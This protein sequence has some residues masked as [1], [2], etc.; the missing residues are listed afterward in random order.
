VEPRQVQQRALTAR[1]FALDHPTTNNQAFPSLHRYIRDS[2]QASSEREPSRAAA[3][4]QS[5]H[6]PFTHS[7]PLVEESSLHRLPRERVLGLSE[8]GLERVDAGRC[9]LWPDGHAQW[10]R[11]PEAHKDDRRLHRHRGRS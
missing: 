11:Q 1:A 7:Q 3:R 8:L 9:A 5:A 10:H 4:A 2:A 6:S